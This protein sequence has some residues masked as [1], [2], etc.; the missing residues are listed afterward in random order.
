MPWPGCR[1]GGTDSQHSACCPCGELAV[2]GSV[3]RDLRRS[4]GQPHTGTSICAVLAAGLGASLTQSD[5][6]N[7]GVRREHSP[8]SCRAYR[9]DSQHEGRSV[10]SV[11]GNVPARPGQCAVRM[12]EGAG[13]SSGDPRHRDRCVPS[14]ASKARCPSPAAQEVTRHPPGARAGARGLH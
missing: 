12:G 2:A 11:L 6:N 9:D 7:P 13:R 8:L 4:G 14:C 10:M 1:R 5:L 3:R